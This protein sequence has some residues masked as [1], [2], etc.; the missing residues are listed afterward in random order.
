MSSVITV[1]ATWMINLTGHQTFWFKAIFSFWLHEAMSSEFDLET[2][3]ASPCDQ[4]AVKWARSFG[5]VEKIASSGLGW[6]LLT[7]GP[8][9][10]ACH[11]HLS[12]LFCSSAVL[13][14]PMFGPCLAPW[15]LYHRGL[16][17]SNVTHS[18]A[19]RELEGPF[20]LDVF[21][22]GLCF[23]TVYWA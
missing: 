23:E 2:M 16:P 18:S 20:P 17:T 14:L 15:V 8:N 13:V 4:V 3:T 9:Q 10:V 11:M 22:C 5:V 6:P 1:T 7:Q 12:Q 19:A 21:S